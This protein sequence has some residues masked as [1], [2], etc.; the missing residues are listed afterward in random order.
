MGA[1]PGAFARAQLVTQAE[2]DALVVPAEAVITFAGVEKVFTV[3]EGKAVERRVVTGDRGPHQ[4]ATGG[5]MKD[6][7][8]HVTAGDA[9]TI[10]A[11][12]LRVGKPRS[13]RTLGALAAQGAGA[14]SAALHT[15]VPAVAALPGAGHWLAGGLSEA[16]V[17][18]AARFEYARTVEDVLARRCRL[19]FLDAAQAAGAAPAVADIL[20]QELGRDPDAGGFEQLAAAYAKAPA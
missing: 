11:I 19:L 9:D 7:A 12:F 16:M 15:A 8:V 13:I 20:R 3:T 4:E 2:S 10:R 17:R 6:Y 18:F 5:W 14:R 1:D